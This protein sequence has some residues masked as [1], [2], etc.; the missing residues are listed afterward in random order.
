MSIDIPPAL[1]WISYLA[2]SKW[3]QGD[4]DGLWR[5]GEHW[6]AA[7]AEMS[8]LIP[9]LNRVRNETM[10]VITGE[11]ANTAAQEFAKLFDGDYSV[12]KLVAAMSALG[13]TARQAGTQ[14]EASKIEI[15]VGLAMAAAEILYAIAMAPWTFGASMA[16]IPPIEA[17]TVAAIRALFNQLLRALVRR[18]VE[19]LT[20]TTV[21]RLV[22]AAAKEGVEE[23][24]EELITNLAIQQYQIDKGHKDK[25]DW[26][27]VGNAAKGAA[28]GG[29][30]AGLF[31]APTFGA[32]GGKHGHGGIG[33]ALAGAGASYGSEVVAGVVGAVAV[34]GDLDAGEIFAG[35]ALG[36]VSG[37]IDSSHG[38]GHDGHGDD[39]PH[40]AP[41]G[42]DGGKSHAFDPDGKGRD[43]KES[44]TKDIGDADPGKD[45]SDATPPY[46]KSDPNGSPPPYAQHSSNGPSDGA[47]SAVSETA[48]GSNTTATGA[49]QPQSH[50]GS[51]ATRDVVRNGEPGAHQGGGHT[52][53]A[54][55][56]HDSTGSQGGESSSQQSPGGNGVQGGSQ[57][58]PNGG[59]T[60]IASSHQS[61][62]HQNSPHQSDGHQSSSDQNSAH[63]GDAHQSDAHQSSSHHGGGQDSP[64]DARQQGS[65][66]HVSGQTAPQQLSGHADSNATE[67]H[68]GGGDSNSSP[69]QHH[70]HPPQNSGGGPEPTSHQLAAPSDTP[71]TRTDTSPQSPGVSSEST[72]TDHG[73]PSQASPPSNQAPSDSHQ[74]GGPPPTEHTSRGETAPADPNA[75]AGQP[76]LTSTAP[77]PSTS[78]APANTPT[79][80]PSTAVAPSPGTPPGP[81]TPSAAPATP[82]TPS[83]SSSPGSTATQAANPVGTNQSGAPAKSVSAGLA[84]SSNSAPT[85]V[86]N[87]ANSTASAPAARST[88]DDR[89]QVIVG[90]V[91]VP[92]TAAPIAPP[93]PPVRAPR[94]AGP[95]VGAPPAVPAPR[96]PRKAAI[97][98]DES[99]RHDQARSADWFAPRDPAPERLWRARRDGAHVRTVD[100]EVADILTDS[101]PTRIEAYDGP[102][103]YDLRRIEV[104]PGRFVQEYTVKVHLRAGAGADS[105]AVAAVADRAR[106]G[107][108]GLLNQG[109]RLPSGDQFHLNLEFTDDAGDAHT[110]VEV[111]T[112]ATDQTHWNPKAPASVLAH[113]TLH[114]L[115]VPDEYA[116]AQRVLLRHDTNSGVHRDDGGMM[117]RDV[118]GDDPGLRPRHL[119]LVERAA[120]SQVSVPD[121]RLNDDPHPVRGDDGVKISHPDRA[122]TDRTRPAPKRERDAESQ[123]DADISGPFKRLRTDDAAMDVDSDAADHDVPMD[124]VQHA[125]DT[126]PLGAPVPLPARDEVTKY[127]KAFEDLANGATVFAPTKDTHLAALNDSVAKDK[128]IAFVVNA[129]VPIS[130]IHQLPEVVKAITANAKGLDGKVAF[131]IGVNTREAP[132][133]AANL[134]SALAGMEHVL[135][136]I[137]QP[138]ALTGA[139]WKMPS[140]GHLPYGT[141]RNDMMHSGVNRFAIAAMVSQGNHPYLAVQDFDTGSRNV[142]SGEHVFNHVARTLTTGEDLP[143]ARP[144]MFSGGYVAPRSDAAYQAMIA[145]AHAKRL[146]KIAALEQ[147]HPTDAEAR[148]KTAA[149]ISRLEKA[150]P[151]LD[152]EGF[153]EDFARQITQD[154]DARVEQAK[155]SP[156]LPYTPEPNLFVD[157]VATLVDPEVKFGDGGAEFSMLGRSL[158][159]FNAAELGAIHDADVAALTSG[160]VNEDVLAQVE[161]ERS[162]LEVNA[163][164]GRHPVRGAA[165]MTDFKGAAV[166]TDLA[167]IALGYATDGKLPQS[168]AALT[169]VADRFFATKDDKGDTSLSKF[170]D[171]FAKR[172]GADREPLHLH[173]DPEAP[174]G[175]PKVAVAPFTQQ[176]D[177]HQQLG[178]T[179]DSAKRPDKK[180]DT[181]KHNLDGSLSTP[182]P[183]HPDVIAG[184]DQRQQTAKGVA[185]VNVAMSGPEASVQRKFASLNDFV[186]HDFSDENGSSRYAAPPPAHGGLFHAVA[187]ARGV[188][189][190]SLRQGLTAH[191]AGPRGKKALTDLANFITDHPTTDGDLVRAI[192]QPGATPA[193]KLDA[194]TLDPNAVLHRNPNPD[195][196]DPPPLT[197]DERAAVDATNAAQAGADAE[198]AR[199]A[200]HIAIKALATQLNTSIVVHD[201]VTGEV[202]PYAPLG[203][204][205]SKSSIELDATPSPDGRHTYSARNQAGPQR[206]TRPA[207]LPDEPIASPSHPTKPDQKPAPRQEVDAA[208]KA[209]KKARR[210][211]EQRVF[212]DFGSPRVIPVTFENGRPLGGSS[213]VRL[214][215]VDGRKVA[216]KPTRGA[217]A[218]KTELLAQALMRAVGAPTLQAT[219]VLVE[220]KGAQI[221]LMSEFLDGK[222]PDRS[223]HAQFGGHPDVARFAAADMI[224]SNWDGHKDDAYLTT[225]RRVVRIDVGGSLDVRAQGAIREGWTSS[226][227][228]ADDFEVDEIK[229]GSEMRKNEP[230]AKLTD[231]QIAD[232]IRTVADRL[233]PEAIDDAIRRSGYPRGEGAEL[234]A[235]LQARIAKALE[236]AD[237]VYPAQE[238]E[239][240]SFGTV[241]ERNPRTALQQLQEDFGYEPTADFVDPGVVEGLRSDTL[242]GNES[243]YTT[244]LSVR[245]SPAADALGHKPFPSE[246]KNEP[247]PRT[248]LQQLEEDFGYEPTT[249]FTD[250][251]VVEDLRSDTGARNESEYTTMLSV[252]NPPVAEALGHKPYAF[253]QKVDATVPEVGP[254]ELFRA[255]QHGD[256]RARK[257][258]AEH[259]AMLEGGVLIRR[260]SE[261]EVEAFETALASDDLMAVQKAL[262]GVDETRSTADRAGSSR[263]ATAPKRGEIVWSL[264]DTFQFTR[265]LKPDT[266][267]SGSGAARHD[268]DAYKKVLEIPVTAEMAR[269]LGQNLYI[270]NPVKGAKPGAFQ[271][272]PNLKYEGTA[273]GANNS[274]G[275]PNVVIKRNGF[276]DFWSTVRKVRVFDAADHVSANKYEP[277]VERVDETNDARKARLTATPEAQQKQDARKVKPVDVLM[278]DEDDVG[279][280]GAIL[281][282]EP[283]PPTRPSPTSRDMSRDMGWD[284]PS[285]R[286]PVRGGPSLV[287]GGMDVVESFRSGNEGL[288]Q[289]RQLVTRLG[290]Q[291]TWDANRERLTALFSDDGLKPKVAGMLRGGK[292]VSYVVELGSGRTLSID[293]RLDGSPAA[294]SLTFKENVADYEFE[295]SSDPSSVVGSFDEG[296]RTYVVGAQAGLTHPNATHIAGVFG[297]REHQWSESRQRT[298]RQISGGQTV[299]PGT[300]FHGDIQA[301]VSYRVS[302][303]VNRMTGATDEAGTLPRVTFRTQVAVPT[304][305]VTDAAGHLAA[306]VAPP[307]VAKSRALT[308]S[309][310]VTNLQLIPDGVGPH[311]GP[312]STSGLVS[313][314]G[315]RAA[316][317]SAYGNKA[318]R[319]MD[320]VDD[321]LSVELLQANLHG[322]TNK[323]PL[324]HHLEG[325]GGRVE[326]HAFVES[327][328]TPANTKPAH[329]EQTSNSADPTMR[330]TGETSRTE[331]HFGTET[332]SARVRQDQITHTAQLPL[333]GRSRGQGG[334]PTAEVVGGLDG[335]LNVGRS[336]NEVTVSQFRNRSTLKNPAAGQAW[337]GQ[338]RLRFVMHGPDSVSPTQRNGAFRG[339]VHETRAEF[340]VLVEKSETTPI[341]DYRGKVVF[342]PPVRIWGRGGPPAERNS[343]TPRSRWQWSRRP[344]PVAATNDVSA[345]RERG[346]ATEPLSGLGSMDRVTNL[347]LSGFHGLLDSMGHRAFGSKWDEVRPTVAASSHLNRI[348][349]G[350]PGMTQH[351]PLT[352]ADLSGPGSSSGL[353]LT[354]DIANLTYRRTIDEVVSSPSMENTEG[355]TTTTTSTEQISAQ[356]ALGGRG[357]V[358]GGA[359]LGEV[360]AGANQTVRE[361]DRTREQQRM[362]VATKFAQPMAIFDGWVRID[363]TMTGPKATV[364]ESGLFPIEIA[365]PLS[366][367]QGSRTH[368]AVQPPTFDRSRPAG[369]AATPPAAIETSSAAALSVPGPAP[370]SWD[371][372]VTTA[373]PPVLPAHALSER[374]QP[375]DML[376]GLDPA[377]GLV[378]AIRADLGPALGTDVDRAMAGVNQEFGPQVLQARLAHQSGRQ[379]S[380]DIPVAG[381]R[382]T[383]KVRA[384]R[385]GD[386]EK[387]EYVGQSTKFETDLS[388]ESQWSKARLHDDLTRHVEGGRLVIPFPHGSAS[389]Q[390]THSG[391]VLPGD[392]P[393]AGGRTTPRAE[394]TVTDTEHR[395]PTRVR[396]TEV[397]DLFRQPVR[398]EI[399]YERH[400]GARLL[401]TV[402]E[403][404]ADVRLT[405]V[406]SYPHV[407][408]A[409]NG[410]AHRLVGEPADGPGIPLGTDHVVTEVR[411]PGPPRAAATTT[412]TPTED[413]MAAHVLDSIAEQGRYVFGDEWPA[414]RA[415][416]AQHVG[417]RA[418]HGGLGD[419]SRGGEKAIELQAVRGGKVVLSARVDAMTEPTQGAAK[420]AEFYT[421]GQTIQTATDGNAKIDNWNAA[422]QVRGTVLP[423]DVGVNAS[424]LGRVDVNRATDSSNTR[425]TTSA[426]GELFRTKAAAHVQ[427]GTATLRATMS[428]PAGFFGR[429]AERERDGLAT[430]DFRIRRPSSNV[431][432]DRYEPRPGTVVDTGHDNHGHRPDGGLPHGSMVRKVLDGHQFRQQTLDNL[433]APLSG[434][435]AS[436][437]RDRLPEALS[438]VNLQRNLPAMTR[439]EE[440][441][442]FR[443]GPLRITGRANLTALDFTR[444]ERE[445]GTT[446]LL[447]EVNHGE[448]HQD[449]SAW[450]AGA[451]FMAGPHGN[452]GDGVRANAMVGVGGVGRVRHGAAY[453]QSAKVSA[454]A[455][456]AGARAAFD[457]AA[458]V[459]LTVH[460]GDSSH[461]LTGIVVHGPMLIPTS[462]AQL[463]DVPTAPVANVPVPPQE[464]P[465]GARLSASARARSGQPQGVPIAGTSGLQRLFGSDRGT[466]PDRPAI[467]EDDPTGSSSRASEESAALAVE[468]T[469]SESRSGLHTPFTTTHDIRR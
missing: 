317:E 160:V 197:A 75:V 407:A 193:P 290:G 89:D 129:I 54:A 348:R 346:M 389:V 23:I 95:R 265:E 464:P 267:A 113:E 93:A 402:P 116:D 186:S 90:M 13:E 439:G 450:E 284:A 196:P 72:T 226:D 239:N 124:D 287:L 445:G 133:A 235:V 406:F 308:G 74:V 73:S 37:G 227:V 238:I 319:A 253:E 293:L 175:T 56:R 150:G 358:A 264:N 202:T 432:R 7:A 22:R 40:G 342:A 38:H 14:V 86:S 83:T 334:T 344:H 115:G 310:V 156:M 351:S 368:D 251:R 271:G 260:M 300:R 268:A 428:R 135:A 343:S 415:E 198:T 9:D 250:P 52:G 423:V 182:I 225:G 339:G 434:I 228:A 466:P 312:Q 240:Q 410:Q 215:E 395:I 349:G 179:D 55:T 57:Q 12:D 45:S 313:S 277:V 427:A 11:T 210:E 314:P 383:V 125:S 320:E 151:K 422:I 98:D 172:G 194:L 229:P 364:H 375:T 411:P 217:R 463:V 61:S 279:L 360:I 50:D 28:A 106:Q 403:N 85:A 142:P 359:L 3:P 325:V 329:G 5:I 263:S 33:N 140:S 369:I 234:K 127:N 118:L 109:F 132:G 237:T 384:I 176:R 51:S 274:T 81:T 467:A 32:L 278:D 396:T 60:D 397:H 336:T 123:D 199:N 134:R 1:Q 181:G 388:M 257:R 69:T 282:D 139:T 341:T 440:V 122:D 306:S 99:W 335:G 398:F 10:S 442:L 143:S 203:K 288:N 224:L 414:V 177:I 161:N 371:P 29:A 399:S 455:R 425:T 64:S 68:T 84:A 321:W 443:D 347:D 373:E 157:A 213:G 404:A 137:D 357:D 47:S 87:I 204:G 327:L 20:K 101:T 433:T 365:I 387:A 393:S 71:P 46:E 63:Q 385:D 170:R 255:S 212:G 315:M 292:P 426:T 258:F 367:L 461:T 219:P 188:S 233:T 223:V 117:G 24:A 394:T 273:G 218:V 248:A 8:D 444:V 201:A 361:G 43:G 25:I 324:V 164:T 418:L 107:V 377:S 105:D 438:D 453:G 216:I 333:P 18:A 454:N 66:E 221:H 26:S 36:G 275:T 457:G 311:R 269:H 158:A 247:E 291:Q 153:R 104:T 114:Y 302:G 173:N 355:A 441:E 408:P 62:S 430:V 380:H 296:R 128:P 80:G 276:A 6:H 130:E 244:M 299:E 420:E 121:T 19:A 21:A 448:S 261:A 190:A 15:L 58:A 449:S 330:A 412:P 354:A 97:I 34:G 286:L 162:N 468:P 65:A 138:V 200:E 424:L 207:P 301:V 345:P 447:N 108:D 352:I 285:P 429:G 304:R 209:E 112:G 152:A 363:G 241:L 4:E 266:A 437:L 323:Q 378:E 168:H 94:K 386:P 245:N 167:R 192:I 416:L 379:W 91:P 70:S 376:I 82:N 242:A 155:T 326:V 111:G 366:E 243:E 79:N 144:L 297:V 131:V 421:G 435:T 183:G 159:R 67:H 110:V 413:A 350:L 469:D 451:R 205:G 328:G 154:M 298:D 49:P 270:S 401:S 146:A 356:A 405:G 208:D 44:A 465:S 254:E 39:A 305:A 100:T 452:L 230:Y 374:W 184:I 289:T 174:K 322:M 246:E 391:S 362:V 35:G 59:S 136:D 27:D 76:N 236:W 340:D 382:I 141:M 459:V 370:L 30:A 180:K 214:H 256:H 283:S 119:W 53:D 353:A 88:T 458:E 165:F 211:W 222:K 381:G 195:D 262:F 259:T 120:N 191:F 392:A 126:T 169:N 16:W 295:H 178:L 189:G 147:Q 166:E 436:R 42:L 280:F 462:Q 145:A 48:E 460:D 185:A 303:P 337:N 331:F 163:Q 409:E 77:D 419:Y 316:F 231:A 103:R 149:A 206:R 431:D 309:D 31:H 148:K 96:R 41:A 92:G 338:V 281:D 2:G 78:A 171:D 318:A 417:T 252:R 456:F 390:V 272:N 249:D 332:D 446:N 307:R 102:V 187:A 17:L 372:P 232:S 400:E 220:G 294:S